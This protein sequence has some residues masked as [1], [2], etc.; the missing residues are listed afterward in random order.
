MGGL[1]LDEPAADLPVA[2]ALISSLK[3]KALSGDVVAFGEVGLAGEIRSVSGAE[4]R[5]G[6]AVRLG[7]KK[8]LLPK[9]NLKGL[10]NPE[11]YAGAELVGVKMLR[12]AYEALT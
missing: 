1:R 4:A 7:F 10:N 6:E 12:D 11:K 2:L 8:I 9:A 3:D 5:V